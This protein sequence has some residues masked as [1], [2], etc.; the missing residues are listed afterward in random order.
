MKEHLAT[1]RNLGLFDFSF[2]SLCE[3]AGSGALAFLERLQTRSIAA[4]EPGRIVYTLLLRDDGSVFIDATLWRHADGKWW[5]FTG[6]GSD[7]AWVAARATGFDVRIRD[8][9]GEFAVLALQGPSSGRALAHL[10][11]EPPVRGLR[12]FRFLE[13]HLRNIRSHVGRLGFSGELG[14][15][16]VLPA[17]EA[18][19]ARKEML[20]LGAVECSFEAADSL[21]IESGYVLFDREIDGRANPRELGLERLVSAPRARFPLSRRLVGLEIANRTASP[22]LPL[23]RVTS[24]CDSPILHR[25]IGLGFADTQDAVGS[26]V[27]LADGRLARIAR[28]PFYDPGRRL[29]RVTPL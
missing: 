27:R 18:S 7:I 14:Y 16:M 25:R 5:L 21:R 11:G 4:L 23:A 8:R 10:I 28:L 19:A 6:R 17:S 15:E 12:Y 22:M 1:R 13:T 20:G 24:E 9:S 26:T 2:M 3:I 29:P